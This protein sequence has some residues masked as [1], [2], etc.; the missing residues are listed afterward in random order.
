MKTF[1]FLIMIAFVACEKDSNDPPDNNGSDATISYKVNDTLVE[2]SGFD[3]NTAQGVYANKVLAGNIIPTTSY[4]LW[5]QLG[6]NNLLTLSFIT[7]SLKTQNYH[8]DSSSVLTNAVVAFESVLFNANLSSVSR[9][10]DFVDINITSYTNGLISGNFT[11][12]M[13]LS[14]NVLSG[15]AGTTNITEGKFK[16]VKMIY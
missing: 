4:H 6:S 13:T 12:R 3:I 15:P 11:G 16:N 5:A 2:I 1:L 10:N 14:P 9:A 7:D 8:Y